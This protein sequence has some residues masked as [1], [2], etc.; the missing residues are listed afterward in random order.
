MSIL[1]AF[2]VV[3]ILPL[4]ISA[5]EIRREASRQLSPCTAAID[6][7]AVCESANQHAAE[8]MNAGG[9]EAFTVVQNVRTGALVVFAAS[10]PESL[11]VTTPVLP[12]SVSKLLLAASWW[13]NAQPDRR[14][15]SYRGPADSRAPA[16][17]LVTLHE[18][19]VGGSDNA[20]RLAALALRQSVGTETVLRDFRR[21]GFGNGPDSRARDGFWKTLSP[22]YTLRLTPVRDFASLSNATS[23]ADWADTLSLGETNLKV[24]GLHISRFLQAVGNGGVMLPPVARNEEMARARNLSKSNEFAGGFRVMKPYTAQRLQAGMR[25]A[26]RRGTAK[27]I[28]NTLG[29]RGWTMGGKTGTGPGP[30]P[31][32]PHSDGWFAG[33]IFDPQ[34]KARFTVATF[35]RRGGFGGG[36]AAKISADIARYLIGNGSEKQ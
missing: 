32:G 2:V 14:F 20:G 5:Q 33:L 19:L 36:N 29:P 3:I 23:N 35:V 10:R 25:D 28:A 18:M 9:L 31:I 21:Y 22:A 13:D 7:G 4:F 11:D 1:H 30:A 15:D 6:I 8:I 24:T 12:L 27:S 16:Q 26:V 34:G 17:R